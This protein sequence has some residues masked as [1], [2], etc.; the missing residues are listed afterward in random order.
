[1]LILLLSADVYVVPLRL[2]ASDVCDY[3]LEFIEVPM[4]LASLIL[5]FILS[6]WPWLS[7]KTF[8]NGVC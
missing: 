8:D 3:T 4:P 5:V 7:V 1:L 2:E 6:I